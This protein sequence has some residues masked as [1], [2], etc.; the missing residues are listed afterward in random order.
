MADQWLRR[1]PGTSPASTRLVC[2][3][4]AGG[5]AAAYAG[6]RSLLPKTVELVAVQYPGRQDRL[7]EPALEDMGELADQVAGAL[8][9]LLDLPL[10]LFG[11][12]MGSAVCYEVARR[13]DGDENFRL[14]RL[15]ASS[16]PAPHQVAGEHRSRLGD[17]ELIDAMR[18]LGGPP[19]GRYDQPRLGCRRHTARRAPRRLIDG[20]RPARVTPLRAPITALGGDSDPTCA[21]GALS[22]WQDVTCG[23][24]QVAVFPGGHHYLGECGAEV[25]ALVRRQL[26]EPLTDYTPVRQPS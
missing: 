20:Y 16:R 6:W 14:R 5:T 7:S 23:A 24:C 15:F 22:S 9:S 25:V 10:S 11:H 18:R 21:V 26:A 8:R 4:H 3:P 2:L 12:S 17:R 19:P 1:W 13:L